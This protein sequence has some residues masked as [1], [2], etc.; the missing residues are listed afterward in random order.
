MRKSLDGDRTHWLLESP[1][2]SARSRRVSSHLRIVLMYFSLLAML[3]VLVPTLGHARTWVAFGPKTYTRGSGAPVTVTDTFTLLN[4]ATQYT[5]RAFNG[6]LQDNQT[7]LVSNSVVLLNGTQVVGSGNFNRSVAEVDVPIT[8]QAFNTL[9]VQV[10]G[11]PG[12][13]LAIEIVGVDNDPP[14]ITASINPPPNAAGW[15]NSNVT[16]S[17]SCSD[18]TSG[19]AFCPSP[20][21]VTTE[22]AAQTV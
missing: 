11:Q 10:R 20:V 13:V 12:G 18:K 4:P 9:S 15:N 19:V 6:G 1:V 7:E 17:F 3:I 14:A 8:P 21:L 2:K 16:V 22:G 5:L